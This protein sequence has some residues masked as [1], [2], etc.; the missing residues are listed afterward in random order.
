MLRRE[1]T[2]VNRLGLHARAAS[3]FVTCATT[4]AS[5]IR[6]GQ[7]GALVDGKS[8]MGVMLLAA[9]QGTVLQ[10]EVEGSDEQEALNALMELI[11]T[12]FDEDE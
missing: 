3:L 11:A 1:I 7:D 2:I 5:T 6:V 12:G 8:I 4:F 9:G 10:L